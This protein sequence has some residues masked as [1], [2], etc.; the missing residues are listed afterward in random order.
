MVN[1]RPTADVDA[2]G[3]TAF[4][5]GS[6]VVLT[7]SAGA[8]WLWSNGATTQSITVNSSGNY[9]VTV[10]GANG[11]TNASA[12]IA[13][14]VSPSPVVTITASPYTRLYPGLT[15]TLTANVSPAGTYTYV[16][17]KNGVIV[18]A[19][20]SPTLLVNI[21]ELGSYT[22]RVTN[23]GGCNGLSLAK[24]IA[25]SSSRRLFIYPNPNTVQTG[26]E[27]LHSLW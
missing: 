14:D 2:S 19:A 17:F 16:W 27:L 13:V 7:A 26:E 23:A 8:S 9:S 20:T 4:C 6:S 15:T 1:A 21:D 11:C 12:A 22:V 24:E 10:T 18:S 5:Q 3:P 25:D